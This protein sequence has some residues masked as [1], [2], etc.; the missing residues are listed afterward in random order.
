MGAFHP[1]DQVFQT[2]PDLGDLHVA[3]FAGVFLTG[4][5]VDKD[6]AARNTLACAGVGDFMFE[7]G[8]PVVF[9]WQRGVGLAA[10]SLLDG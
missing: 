10:T 4:S 2:R 8:D 6:E 1:A 7:H 9:A 5:A 3:T